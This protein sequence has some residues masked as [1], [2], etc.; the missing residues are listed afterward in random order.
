M[1]STAIS[2]TPSG[3][4]THRHRVAVVGQDRAGLSLAR[5]AVAAGHTV[6]GFDHD[7]GR[8][9]RLRA[10]RSPLGDELVAM[11]ET[12]RYHAT[13]DPAWLAGC[14]VYLVAAPVP[15]RRGRPDLGPVLAA[16]DTIAGHLRDH[17][18]VVLES[19]VSPG[20]TRGAFQEALAARSSARFYLAFSPE[21]TGRAKLAGGVDRRSALAAAAFLRTTHDVVV[22]CATAEEA[23]AANLAGPAERRSA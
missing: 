2:T 13:D 21:R 12:G 15:L 9:A 3:P 19:W 1:R 14:D 10:G 4:A 23:E 20:T 18:L 22:T 6:A 16:A 7:P 8:I 5:A 17:D 11:H